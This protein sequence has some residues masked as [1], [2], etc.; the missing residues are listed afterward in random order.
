MHRIAIL[1]AISVFLLTVAGCGSG[2]IETD[3]ATPSVPAVQPGGRNTSEPASL[4]TVVPVTQAVV[5]SPV[6][7]ELAQSI[8]GRWVCK[9]KLGA[10]RSYEFYRDGRVREGLFSDANFSYEVVS[11]NSVVVSDGSGHGVFRLSGEK[12]NT[13]S[14]ELPKGELLT[15]E[16][17]PPAPDLATNIV[18]VW[19]SD[20]TDEW[21]AFAQD[22]RVWWYGKPGTYQVVSGNSLMVQ[23]LTGERRSLPVLSSTPDALDLGSGVMRKTAG[24][25][26]LAEKIVGF[27]RFAD[28]SIRPCWNIRRQGK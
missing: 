8:V 28:G 11:E 1:V 18:G 17:A 12:G 19:Q 16:L 20:H 10:E 27:W 24:I 14:F 6:S 2:P 9:D 4:P 7:V 13:G 25:P 3:G 15:C 21:Y 26:H 22:G 5:A 23:L